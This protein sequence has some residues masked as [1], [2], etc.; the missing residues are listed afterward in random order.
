MSLIDYTISSQLTLPGGN[1]IPD[2]HIFYL[3][4][5]GYADCSQV[6]VG[7]SFGVVSSPSRGVIEFN[8]HWRYV[9]FTVVERAEE[10]YGGR[11]SRFYVV[12]RRDGKQLKRL[13]TEAEI[14]HFEALVNPTRLAA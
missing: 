13:L 6:P 2:E 9:R 8:H 5:P 11:L 12:E 1:G 7:S 10:R 3:L 4:P 14:A